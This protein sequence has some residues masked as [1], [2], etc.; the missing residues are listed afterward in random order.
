M[1]INFQIKGLTELQAKLGKMPNEVKKMADAVLRDG[2]ANWVLLAKRDAPANYGK[3]KQGITF[4]KMANGSLIGYTVTSN[5][6][7]SAF[8]E[9]GTKGKA[10]IPADQ[11]EY[12]AEF[13]GAKG[14]SIDEFFLAIFEWVKKKGIADTYSTGIVRRGNSYTMDENSIM[15]SGRRKRASDAAIYDA[16]FAI[17]MSIL[18]KG[19][20]PHPFFFKQKPIIEKKIISDFKQIESMI[21]L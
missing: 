3:L 14:G 9:W 6:N 12:A 15:R 19:V 10:V 8:M 13:K 17:M 1:K 11:S 18:K 4:K 20:T 5:S 16:A 2:A 21:K 7:Y